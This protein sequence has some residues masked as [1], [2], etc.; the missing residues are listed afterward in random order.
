M[1]PTS[2]ASTSPSVWRE[3]LELAAREGS[4]RPL[5]ARLLEE[6]R[7]AHQATG[8]A[9]YL[10][11]EVGFHRE[12]TCGSGAFPS[13]FSGGNRPGDLHLSLASA[14][15][16]FEGAPPSGITPDSG[17]LVALASA[18]RAYLLERR[19]KRQRFEVNYRGVELDALYDVG[20]AIASTL[21]LEDL[22]EE[23]L[24]R[25]VSLLDARRGALYSASAGT[26]TLSRTF[27]GEARREFSS[28]EAQVARLL[29]GE[30]G[31][32]QDL[33]P[34]AEH[35][36]A[37]PIE[38]E[39]KSRGLLLMGDK[40]SRHGVGPFGTADRRT[41]ALFANQAAIALENAYLHRQA[42]EKERL[43]RETELAAEIQRRLLP[44]QI[45]CFD[46]LE[47]A[48]WSRPARQI[49]GDFYDL[50][51]L[52]G[53]LGAVVA[54]VSGKGVPAALMVSTLHSALH[55]LIDWTPL[56]PELLERLNH[57]IFLSSAPNKF[58]TLVAAEIDPEGGEVQYI[59]AGHNP[60]LVVRESGEVRS[61]EAS[62]PPLGLFARGGYASDSLRLDKGDVL[63]FFSDGITE[64][65]DRK[66]VE[67]G[68]GRLIDLLRSNSRQSLDE[69]V[70]AIDGATS[71][72]AQGLPQGDDQTLVLLRKT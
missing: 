34:G 37:A 28:D 29:A 55:L 69:I 8:A 30:T 18:V 58:I 27:G 65:T 36:L 25:A 51:R 57:H 56:G 68:E 71:R 49:G 47:L 3:Y 12:V 5:V 39:S 9:L 7:I 43:E 41:L 6:A 42:L 66:D 35:L 11:D 24:L 52:P 48:A 70:Q 2:A 14:E 13:R 63:C 46:G 10:R 45:P 72:F 50:L 40:E 62:G 54:D 60:A 19:L 23:I 1:A 17:M 38:V 21:N 32:P 33:M 44:S 64:T 22:S 53:G 59:N 26:Y 15:V 67:F 31:G 20:L 16:A 61:L 4:S